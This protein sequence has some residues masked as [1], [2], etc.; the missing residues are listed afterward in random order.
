MSFVG[1]SGPTDEAES[2]TSLAAMLDEGI[3]A[4][5]TAK[6]YGRGMSE[7]VIGKWPPHANRTSELSPKP[8]WSTP[9]PA[10]CGTTHRM[11]RRRTAS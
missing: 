11:P 2:L 6:I 7:N 1:L 4:I 10:A 5:D 3:T 9:P 8:A